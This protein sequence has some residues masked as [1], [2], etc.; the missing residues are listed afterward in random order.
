MIPTIPPKPL[1]LLA[2][3]L[4]PLVAHAQPALSLPIR[5]E[6][7]K[8]CFVQNY[9]DADPGPGAKDYRCGFLTYDGHKGTDIRVID[10]AMFGRGVEVVAAAAGRVRAVR[11]AMADVAVSAATKRAVKGREAGNSVVVQH[12]DGWETQYAHMRLGSIAVRPGERVEAGQRLGIVGLS[13]ETAFP[14]LHFEVRHR[15]KPVDPFVGTSGG[16]ACASG[17]APLWT[18]LAAS[19]LAYV[20]TG[21]IGAGIASSPP[22]LTDATAAAPEAAKDAPALVFWV[23]LY[24]LRA[25]DVGELRLVAPDGRALASRQVAFERN[26]AQSLAYVG[27]KRPPAGWP[28][29]AY[30]GEYRLLR[31]GEEVLRVTRQAKP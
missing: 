23:Q 31:N 2:W 29:G 27:K 9:V 4:C 22:R 1:L 14:H 15:G 28:A 5:C 18:A 16:E 10:R 7:G 30:V 13:G 19:S 12:G 21:L 6:I 17:R 8:S 26:L 20:S 11:D 3:L 24:G 25:G